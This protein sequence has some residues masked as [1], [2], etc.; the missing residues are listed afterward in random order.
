[1]YITLFAWPRAG[2]AELQ[3]THSPHSVRMPAASSLTPITN[4]QL[5]R[6]SNTCPTR[7][8]PS[9]PVSVSHTH[10][11]TLSHTHLLP[12]FA[13]P[14]GLQ[15]L[16]RSRDYPSN[17]HVDQ[18]PTLYNYTSPCPYESWREPPLPTRGRRYV[19]TANPRQVPVLLAHCGASGAA[20]CALALLP[21]NPCTQAG[22]TGPSGLV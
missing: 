2:I 17:S 12:F 20:I 15:T 8:A 5:C 7:C 21:L 19:R 9:R 22:N 3:T 11:L 14:S 18:V 13:F 10:T 1:M 6:W 4:S 16:L